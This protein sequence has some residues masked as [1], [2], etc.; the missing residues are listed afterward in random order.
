MARR[1]GAS[2]K[3]SRNACRCASRDIDPHFR[4]GMM[5]PMRSECT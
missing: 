1:H 2:R 5:P 3:D 4:A